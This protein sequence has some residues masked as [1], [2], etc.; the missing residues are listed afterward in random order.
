MVIYPPAKQNMERVIVSIAIDM[1][2]AIENGCASGSVGH[3]VSGIDE[4][5]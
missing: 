1:K 3:S 5:L 4:E 2:S